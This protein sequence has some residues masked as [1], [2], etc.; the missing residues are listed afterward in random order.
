MDGPNLRLELTHHETVDFTDKILPG[1]EAATAAFLT[2]VGVPV[3]AVGVVGAALALH[4]AWEIPAIKAA[5]K[6]GGVFLTAPLF[7]FAGA[8]L[9]PST[10]YE[11][12]NDGWS[13]KAEDVIGSTEG[14]V[15]ETHVENSGDPNTVVF[16]LRNEC[17]S[18]WDKG[19]VLRDGLGGEW[20]L[21]A[22]PFN[23]AENGLWA[24]QVRNGQPL[25]F[26]KPK[27][28][29]AWAEIFSISHLERLAP[30]AVVTFTWKQD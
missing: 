23:Q 18:R 3:F 7:P 15:I 25:T 10:R 4:A 6:G 5:D 16:R 17:P 22:T 1:G 8:I 28:L 14:D 19:L 30:G 20:F 2:A 26:W 27:F 11:Y 24:D 9:I 12:D 21:K 29:G 13:S